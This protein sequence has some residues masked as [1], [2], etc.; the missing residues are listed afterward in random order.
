M[1]RAS[2]RNKLFE[3]ASGEND[4]PIDVDG[5]IKRPWATKSTAISMSATKEKSG[6]YTIEHYNNNANAEG[7][8]QKQMHT[9]STKDPEQQLLT[10]KPAYCDTQESFLGYSDIQEM[11]T[12]AKLNNKANTDSK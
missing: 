5:F 1:N 4:T 11:K 7:L 12:T 8:I 9:A 3:A 10:I 6:E 2:G